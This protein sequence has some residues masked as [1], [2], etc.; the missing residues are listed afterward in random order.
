MFVLVKRLVR[1]VTG[2]EQPGQN[3]HL[4]F[5]NPREYQAWCDDPDERTR[6]EGT[7]DDRR[8]A[9]LR[10]NHRGNREHSHGQGHTGSK[11]QEQHW[12]QPDKGRPLPS[13]NQTSPSHKGNMHAYHHADFADRDHMRMPPPSGRSQAPSMR[14]F[15]R[16]STNNSEADARTIITGASRASKLVGLQDAEQME[17][18]RRHAEAF[19][20]H[21]DS[22][23]WY[24]SEAGLYYHL[25]LRGTEP[26]LPAAWMVDFKTFPLIL[27]HGDL[28]DVPLITNMFSPQFHAIRALRELIEVGHKVRDQIQA[29][30]KTIRIQYT[31]QKGLEDYI[32]WSLTDADLYHTNRTTPIHH[33]AHRRAGQTTVTAISE[34][35]SHM[36]SLLVYHRQFFP[37]TDTLTPPPSPR[38]LK[39]EPKSITP[40]LHATSTSPTEEDRQIHDD[41]PGAD[42]PVIIGFL[43][44]GPTASIFTLNARNAD[45]ATTTSDPTC[46]IH[47]LGRF[48]FTEAGMDVWNALA[49]AIGACHLRTAL[50]TQASPDVDDI[51]ADGGVDQRLMEEMRNKQQE[52]NSRMC[53]GRVAGYVSRSESEE[54]RKRKRNEV[55]DETDHFEPHSERDVKGKC[56]VRP[57]VDVG[58][59][60]RRATR[61]DDS[62]PDR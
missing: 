21:P 23:F 44:V 52:P 51:G 33:I 48:T 11:P 27:F 5:L 25:G 55:E 58:A 1:Y 34:L 60:R 3:D 40:H 45:A 46:G 14:R 28:E 19:R 24:Q 32:S 10:G 37:S 2:D 8:N 13:P 36:Y 16:P 53:H 15:I 42:P 54:I 41:S 38:Q 59:R 26:L 31:I 43:I 50:L 35:A 18:A 56:P 12:L 39:R 9:A 61:E 7:D 4:P 57:N 20:I 6:W 47:L 17:R 29:R 62:D 30:Q 49:L 22:G